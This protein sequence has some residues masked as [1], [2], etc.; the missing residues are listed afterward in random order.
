MLYWVARWI[1]GFLLQV[2]ST[3]RSSENTHILRQIIITKVIIRRVI[4][5][6]IDRLVRE[7]LYDLLLQGF[8]RILRWLLTLILS[9]RCS[10]AH[11]RTWVLIDVLRQILKVF[12]ELK[13]QRIIFLRANL[14]YE[15]WALSRVL[16]P[17]LLQWFLELL[18]LF[19]QRLRFLFALNLLESL[20]VMIIFLRFRVIPILR[21]LFEFGLEDTINL[22]LSLWVLIRVC[23]VR[24]LFKSEVSRSFL[25]F[26]FILKI[27]VEEVLWSILVLLTSLLFVELFK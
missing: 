25:I 5:H 2:C 19:D 6:F 8:M 10:R 9:K 1:R 27:V 18:L 20:I 23:I 4:W 14:T 3:L 13:L 15:I 17:S 16:P 21:R 11:F 24:V 26:V 12:K 22:H 7:L